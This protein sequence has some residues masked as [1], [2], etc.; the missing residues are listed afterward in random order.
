M[1][2]TSIKAKKKIQIPRKTA[3]YC[4]KSLKK[5]IPS[6]LGGALE[7]RKKTKESEQPCPHFSIEYQPGPCVSETGL[8]PREPK[9]TRLRLSLK[10]NE[11]LAP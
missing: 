3:D 11:K 7:V 6:D 2:S 5:T 9:A 4:M 1:T 8:A 10:N